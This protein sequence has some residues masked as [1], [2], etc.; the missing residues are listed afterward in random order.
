MRR[1]LGLRYGFEGLNPEIAQVIELTPTE[2]RGKNNCKVN[3]FMVLIIL[4]S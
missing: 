1:I 2:V 4:H 3:D